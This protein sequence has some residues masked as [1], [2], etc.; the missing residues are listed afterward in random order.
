MKRVSL[1]GVAIGNVVDI[2][3]TNIVILPLIVYILASSKSAVAPNDVA[4]SITTILKESTVFNISSGILG[5]LCSILGG[6]VSS[7][8]AKHDELLNGAL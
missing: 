6:Y 3:S 4:N 5:G 7:R 8:L 2:V 1:K